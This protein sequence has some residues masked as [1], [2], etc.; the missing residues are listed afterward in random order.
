MKG[1]PAS[2]YAKYLVIAGREICSSKGMVR[3]FL[4]YVFLKGSAA[5]LVD[6]RPAGFA[7]EMN[8][9]NLSLHTGNEVR[10]QGDPFLLSN[11]VA[12]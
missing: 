3:N 7:P 12:A 4:N 9:R 8:L 1:Q 6:K 10:K 11:L 2:L 5:K